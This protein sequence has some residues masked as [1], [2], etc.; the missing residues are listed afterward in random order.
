MPSGPWRATV[1][2]PWRV[3]F[4]LGLFAGSLALLMYGLLRMHDPGYLYDSGVYRDMGGERVLRHLPLYD[5][6][7]PSGLSGLFTYPPF[8]ALLFTQ[9]VRMP[10]PVYQVAFPAA[11]AIALVASVWVCLRM[12]GRRAGLQRVAE[13]FALGA[14]LLW[15]QPVRWTMFL[16]QINLFLLAMVLTDLAASRRRWYRG[17][18]I[19][20]ASGIKL[21]PALFIVYLVVTRQFRTAATAAATF[22]GTIAVAFAVLPDDSAAFWRRAV[23]DTHRI[24][25]QSY[26]DNQSLAGLLARNLNVTEVPAATALAASAATACAGLG[27]AYLAHRRGHVLAGACAAGLTGLLVSPISWSHHWVWLVPVFVLAWAGA[28]RLRTGTRSAVARSAVPRLPVARSAVARSAVARS[29][30]AR[31]AVARLAGARLAGPRSVGALAIVGIVWFLLTPANFHQLTGRGL[32]V[33]SQ[34]LDLD[35]FRAFARDADVWLGIAALAA[36]AILSRRRAAPSGPRPVAGSAALRSAP[37]AALSFTDERGG[38]ATAEEAG[39][40]P[41]TG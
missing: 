35:W 10:T 6:T 25:P 28:L 31:S 8:A 11:C 7:D 23:F 14:F 5:D 40:D 18:A 36:I 16:G 15:I 9:L 3:V 12:V 33:P 39:E 24:G 41:G 27:I 17:I 1:S 29:A 34:V 30:V 13:A 32:R 37:Q 26:D 2:G 21:T 4:A 19:G 38:R 22:L 20:L